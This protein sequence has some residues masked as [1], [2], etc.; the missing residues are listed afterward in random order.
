MGRTIW[1][2]TTNQGKVEEARDHVSGYGFEIQQLIVPG[3]ELVEPQ[4][5]DIVEVA[6]SKIEQARPHL[7]NPEDLLLVE[8]AG[9]FVIALHGFPGVY[10]AY[11]LKTI[12]CQGI[13]RLLNHLQSDDP[14]QEKKLREAEF[15][16]VAALWDGQTVHLG[17][18][19]CPGSIATSAIE[20]EGFGFD[21]IFV[22][23]DLDEHRQPLKPGE[24]G[25]YSA[26]G[27]TFGGMK[28]TEKHLY[29]HRRRALDHLLTL[30][31]VPD[32]NQR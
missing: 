18:G 10:S 24:L 20:G 4:T 22:P 3:L 14:V 16:A 1:F 7:P 12:D 21:P 11:A 15:Q 32:S 27:K 19:T 17:H 13:L 26:H 30:L 31:P 5:D 23:A 9:L 6:M 25:A 8:D 29:S 2:L 28:M